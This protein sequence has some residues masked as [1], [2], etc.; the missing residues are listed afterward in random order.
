MTFVSTS[1]RAIVLVLALAGL[2]ACGSSKS[3][4]NSGGVATT[5]PPRTPATVAP[6]QP[7]GPAP[8][9][10]QDFVVNVGDRVFFGFDSSN[11]DSEAQ[12]TLRRQAAWLERYPSTTITVEGHCDERGTRAYNL[13]LGARRANAVKQYLTSLGVNSGRIKTI[14]YGKERPVALCS[15]ESCWSQNRRGVTVINSGATS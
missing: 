3:S 7:T 4:T 9:S 2:A 11:L 5:T 1:F 13:A 15:N 10:E 6:P 8:G 12:E 14:S